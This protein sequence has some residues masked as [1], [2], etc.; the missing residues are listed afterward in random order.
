MAENLQWIRFWNGTEKQ[1]PKHIALDPTVQK[2]QN[3]EPINKQGGTPLQ[4]TEAPVPQKKNVAAVSPDKQ[5]VTAS[6]DAITPAGSPAKELYEQNKA[7]KSFAEIA[8]GLGIHWRAVE[9]QVAEYKEAN[10][11]VDETPTQSHDNH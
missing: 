5:E 6:A 9:K 10:N 3:F 2:A 7:G 8:K 11:I 1:V 4:P